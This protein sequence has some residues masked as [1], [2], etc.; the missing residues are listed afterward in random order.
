MNLVNQLREIPRLYRL[1]LAWRHCLVPAIK[2]SFWQFYRS[3][4]GGLLGQ[5]YSTDRLRRNSTRYARLM[6]LRHGPPVRQFSVYEYDPSA[7]D[8]AER[9][10]I[11]D[12]CVAIDGCLSLPQHTRAIDARW[13]DRSRFYREQ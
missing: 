3:L 4:V 9:K 11:G 6:N 8:P 2:D 13:F 12:A 10:N 1:G 7:N 5:L